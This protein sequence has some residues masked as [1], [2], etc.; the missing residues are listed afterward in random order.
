[1]VS[2]R[3]RVRS[4]AESIGPAGPRGRIFAVGILL[5]LLLGASCFAVFAMP[6]GA[7][8]EAGEKEE[9]PP[10]APTTAEMEAA[11]ANRVE[12]RTPAEL[13]ASQTEFAELP[14]GE[15]RELLTEEFPQE[16]EGLE[17]DPARP[18]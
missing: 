1:M 17:A 4:A 5:A 9:V 7:A 6:Q 2:R 8:A 14:A 16:L 13:Q 10:R 18:S 15:A 3:K 11:V 12:H